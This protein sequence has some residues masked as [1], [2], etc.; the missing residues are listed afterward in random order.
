MAMASLI[1]VR[2]L[3]LAVLVATVI[4]APASARAGDA[5]RRFPQNRLVIGFDLQSRHFVLEA[6]GEV[7]PMPVFQAAEG[8]F[9]FHRPFGLALDVVERV[10][11]FESSDP[12]TLVIAR[13]RGRPAEL[14]IPV[15]FVGR[16]DESLEELKENAENL[17]F[18]PS[19]SLDVDAGF[20]D[21]S[22][23][24][25]RG[26]SRFSDIKP[27]FV[28]GLAG[29]L[30]CEQSC[31]EDSVLL[32][33]SLVNHL[34]C[35]K[36]QPSLPAPRRG[37]S[38]AAAPDTS[39]PTHPAP[40]TQPRAKPQTAPEPSASQR[41]TAD[42]EP[43]EP[44]RPS[45]QADA[46]PQATPPAR[47]PEGS[48]PAAPPPSEAAPPAPEI[49]RLVLAFERKASEPLPP[50]DIVKAE[51]DISVEGVPLTLTP[52]GLAASLPAEALQKANDPDYWQRLFRHHRIVSVKN[53]PDRVVLTVEPL[54]IKA[55]DLTIE[56]LDASSEPV[57]GCDLALVVFAERRIGPGWARIGEKERLRGLEYSEADTVYQLASPQEAQ[58]NDLLIGTTGTGNAARLA[59]EAPGC[60]L[61][62]RPY[63][64]VEELRTGRIRRSL[65]TTGPALISI[66]STDSGFEEAAGQA[67]VQSYWSEA[68]KLISAVSAAPFER[69]VLARAQTPESSNASRVLQTEREGALATEDR[70]AEMLKELAEG[71]R[72][73][74][75]PRS[76]LQNRAVGPLQIDLALKTIRDDASISL[77]H[78]ANQEML[79]FVS[80]R[81]EE[82]GSDF[83]QYSPRRE[84]NPWA[85]PPW[86]KQLHKALALEIWSE[87]AIRAMRNAS[88]IKAAGGAPDGVFVCNIPG[89]DGDRIALYGLAPKVLPDPGA[90]A[91]AFAY[92]T[93]QAG[94]FL[95]P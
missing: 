48:L 45:K 14:Q 20:A 86:A 85:S 41:R 50:E 87:T 37:A 32:A 49:K 95:K 27:F 9:V 90:R 67:S 26:G 10:S 6:K 68:L 44:A 16:P 70:H 23:H 81:V 63:V 89:A 38:E 18:A 22:F 35:S 12:R 61:E 93:E 77:R 75:G 40:K 57:R 94:A 88:R 46:P 73:R 11:L 83:C 55:E 58:A 17:A 74:P 82:D 71:S 91:K 53:Q 42:A 80:G 47:Q 24:L 65:Q 72:V 21:V 33:A 29:L 79:L 66:V 15:F 60:E 51:G 52:E 31:P 62:P 84:K 2:L 5:C 4:I 19:S 13:D 39:Q 76:L 59:N 30:V 78:S 1:C 54:Y 34:I 25:R 64:T 69:K 43:P 56:I 8:R 7:E 92:L 3:A 36:E 28:C